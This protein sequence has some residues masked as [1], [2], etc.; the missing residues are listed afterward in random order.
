MLGGD[1][2]ILLVDVLGCSVAAALE[3]TTPG[4]RADSFSMD[5]RGNVLAALCNDGTARLYD[6]S[7]VRAKQQAHPPRALRQLSPQQ[8]EAHATALRASAPMALAA[9]QPASTKAAAQKHAAEQTDTPVLTDIGNGKG[10]GGSALASGSLAAPA[11]AKGAAKAPRS[12]QRSGTSAA[13]AVQRAAA[14]LGPAVALRTRALNR[15]GAHLC[16]LLSGAR[17]GAH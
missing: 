5:A 4:A 9:A 3:L 17:N 2:C 7:V 1:G 12:P 15:P 16:V 10:R 11:A 8:L 6:L 14:K 13:A